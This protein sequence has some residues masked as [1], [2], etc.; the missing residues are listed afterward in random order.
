MRA[1]VQ[2]VSSASVH[3]S[4]AEH[5]HIG[6][7]MLILLGVEVGDTEE[8]LEWLCGKLVRLRIF[9]DAEGVMNLDITQVQGEVML[10]SQFT[11]LAGTVKG[12]RPSYIRAARPEEAVPLYLRAKQRLSELLGRPVRSGEFGADMQVGLVNDGPVTIVMDSKLRE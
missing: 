12:N 8:E 11:L 5:A 10:V 3:I 9:P 1:V 7:G 2:R 6:R 4:G